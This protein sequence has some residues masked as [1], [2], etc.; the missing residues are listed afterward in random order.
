[1]IFKDN[2]ER[3][4]DEFSQMKKNSVNSSN[5][6]KETDFVTFT[7]LEG[8]GKRI[9]FVGNSIT[10]HGI[11]HD[12]GWHNKW[13][14][15]ASAKENDYVHRLMAEFDEMYDNPAYCVCQV[16]SWERV[17]KEGSTVH[18]YYENARAFDADIIITRFIENCPSDN[19]DSKVFKEEYGKLIDYL[20]KSGKA[21][22]IITTGFWKH[23]GDDA[24]CEYAKENNLPCA[25]LGDLGELDEMK[26]IGLFEHGGVANHPGDLGMEKI[27][28]RIRK[29]IN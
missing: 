24:I 4:K 22:V 8:D 11:K 9:M 27:A 29:L 20:N 3:E 26:A 28:E 5:Q 15:A 1:M 2:D 14:M 16:A 17:Y 13:G 18:E 19:F 23:P 21:Q 6:L 12:I 10:L 7:N 25:Y